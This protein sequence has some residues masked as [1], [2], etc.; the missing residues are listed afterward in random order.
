MCTVT[1]RL[2]EAGATAISNA[3]GSLVIAPDASAQTLLSMVG[4]ATSV[5]QMQ[6]QTVGVSKKRRPKSLGSRDAASPAAK[7]AETASETAA[8]SGG[9]DAATSEHH[10]RL[11]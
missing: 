3:G 6:L 5:A 4:A 10:E 9:E 11:E 8:G 2:A 7:A 1:I